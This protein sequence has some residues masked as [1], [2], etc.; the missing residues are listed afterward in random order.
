MDLYDRG[1]T[2]YLNLTD[3]MWCVKSH[4]FSFF[5]TRIQPIKMTFIGNVEPIKQIIYVCNVTRALFIDCELFIFESA[6]EPI[7]LEAAQH[8]GLRR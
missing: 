8:L 2:L 6:L 1:I 5:S 7:F 4:D 3:G